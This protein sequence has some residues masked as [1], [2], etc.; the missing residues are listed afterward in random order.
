M[1]ARGRD[2]TSLHFV[3]VQN[4]ALYQRQLLHLGVLGL[5][6]LFLRHPLPL[7]G[8][9]SGRCTVIPNTILPVLLLLLNGLRFHKAI[10]KVGDFPVRFL[11]GCLDG[12]V[13]REGEF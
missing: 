4:G 7:D 13:L 10:R 6:S 5:R 12:R 1:C 9:R 2:A 8:G 11:G 3:R